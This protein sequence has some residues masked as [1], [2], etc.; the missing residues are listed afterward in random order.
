M[1]KILEYRADD[2]KYH[3]EWSTGS[4]SQT[5]E[6]LDVIQNIAVLKR[7]LEKINTQTVIPVA[8]TAISMIILN[9][10]GYR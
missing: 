6:P 4:P 2:N 5:W 3:V 9:H 8:D 10:V 7:W 1:K